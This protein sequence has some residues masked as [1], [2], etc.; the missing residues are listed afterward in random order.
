MAQ[1]FR[2][3]LCN[4]VYAEMLKKI[5]L[6]FLQLLFM[7]VQRTGFFMRKILKISSFLAIS[8]KNKPTEGAEIFFFSI[9]NQ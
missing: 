8:P 9:E 4:R 2:A 7:H 3:R 5:Y 6:E 1:C